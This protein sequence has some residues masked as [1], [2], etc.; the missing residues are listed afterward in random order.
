MQLFDL[1]NDSSEQIDV[2][3]KYPEIVARLKATY[4]EMNRDVP[5]EVPNAKTI[6]LKTK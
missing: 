6:E 5:S 1:L 2:A 4:D 3:S